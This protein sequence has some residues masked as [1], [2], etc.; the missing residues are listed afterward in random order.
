MEEQ[1]YGL[2]SLIMFVVFEK[3]VLTLEDDQ[4]ELDLYF[5]PKHH[6]RMKQL[7]LNYQKTIGIETPL[8]GYW[9]ETGEEP[10][11]L[12]A[13]NEEQARELLQRNGYTVKR[14]KML[15]PKEELVY[16]RRSGMITLRTS[17]R[18]LAEEYRT[19]RVL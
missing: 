15:D 9:A 18:A 7:L 17:V 14:I 3:Q 5:K 4:S 1:Y 13:E 8:L 12:L 11:T 2:Q 19:A 16:V 6:E 10:V